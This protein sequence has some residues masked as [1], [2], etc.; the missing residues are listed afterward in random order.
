MAGRSQQCSNILLASCLRNRHSHSL[1]LSHTQLNPSAPKRSPIVEP[2]LFEEASPL[3][4]DPAQHEKSIQNMRRT[5][6]AIKRFIISVRVQFEI[7]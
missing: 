1:S 4:L 7:S 2:P 3:P 5:C 6:I